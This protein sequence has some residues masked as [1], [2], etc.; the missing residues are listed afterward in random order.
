[1]EKTK[2]NKRANKSPTFPPCRRPSPHLFDEAHEA[3]AEPPG[4]VAVALQRVDR[5]L[6]GVLVGHGHNVDG[7]VGQSCVCLE[8]R[9]ERY[10]TAGVRPSARPSRG[11]PMNTEQHRET[12]RVF[13]AGATPESLFEA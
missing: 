6:R 1:M 10:V 3:A 13:L 11:R 7:V 12:L 4:L 9:G 8:L 5:H 2:Q